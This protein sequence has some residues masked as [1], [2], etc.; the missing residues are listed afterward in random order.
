MTQPARSAASRVGRPAA[1]FCVEVGLR[2]PGGRFLPLARSNVITTPRSSPSP[3][4]TV[5]WIDLREDAPRDAIV[6]P[7]P[8]TRLPAGGENGAEAGPP[9]DRARSSDLHA[10]RPR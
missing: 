1:T 8:G 3:D 10:P 4:T 6:A 7:W 5:R 2:T 9:D